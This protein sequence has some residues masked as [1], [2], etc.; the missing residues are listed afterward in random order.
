MFLKKSELYYSDKS[1]DEL[2]IT[3]CRH[4]L[5]W[6]FEEFEAYEKG[7]KTEEEIWKELENNDGEEFVGGYEFF[8]YPDINL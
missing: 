4:R 7:V 3:A 8:L 5:A 1:K 6:T 2:F